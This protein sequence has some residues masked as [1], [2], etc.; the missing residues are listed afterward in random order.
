MG[1][2]SRGRADSFAEGR[3]CFRLTGYRFAGSIETMQPMTAYFRD[4]VLEKRPYIRLEWCLEALRTPARRE[5]QP[6]DGR[7]RHWI[8]VVS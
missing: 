1:L 2:T 5:V 6:E 3:A 7:I 8:W 4:D